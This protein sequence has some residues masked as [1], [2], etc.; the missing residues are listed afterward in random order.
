MTKKQKDRFDFYIDSFACGDM[1]LAVS[2]VRTLACLEVEEE[3]LQ[4]TIN[5]VGLTYETPN[6]QR[7]Q[8]PE[9]QQIK[10]DRA[11]KSVIIGKLNELISGETQNSNPLEALMDELD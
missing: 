9:W 7:R 10:E 5:K 8:N 3:Q 2:L 6:G 4:A 11:R 1:P